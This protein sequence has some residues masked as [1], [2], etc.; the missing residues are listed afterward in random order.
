MFIAC[1]MEKIK[2]SLM[3]EISEMPFNCMVDD[4]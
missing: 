4:K 1:Y 2:I 3:K